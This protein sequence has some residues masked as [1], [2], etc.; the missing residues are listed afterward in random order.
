MSD[1]KTYTTL[2]L[3]GITRSGDELRA[4]CNEK[5]SQQLEEWEKHIYTFVLEWLNDK[6]YIITHTSGSTGKPKEIQ[7]PKNT[8]VESAKNTCTFFNLTGGSKALLCIPAAFIGGKMMLVRG[9]VS[10]MDVKTIKPTSSPLEQISTCY[11][12]VALTP[13]QAMQSS[14]KTLEYFANIIIGG[15]E[16]NT[17]L[18]NK[19]RE[20]KSNYY[21]TYGMTETASHVALKQ[22]GKQN[23]FESLTN[24]TFTKDERD[25]LIIDAPKLLESPLVTND[26]VELLSPTQFIWKGRF[27]NVI[28]SGGIK[29][30]PEEVE[31]KLEP[32]ITQPFFIGKL[33]DDVL[34]EKVVLVVESEQELTIDFSKT[35]LS[36]YEKPKQIIY[37]KQ[38]TE[39]ESGKIK[40]N[41]F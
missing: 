29:I 5:L 30:Y 19:L 21:S 17:T 15:G 6:N 39:T 32:F 8:L 4:F 37:T 28:N 16:V 20:V 38:F 26:V 33:P 31:K 9:F 10:G 40:R 18:E 34:G 1:Y 41:E 23:Y 11:H 2:T 36:V 35:S 22:I 12:F 27:D 7:L 25:C 3:N 13:Q 24:I 14:K